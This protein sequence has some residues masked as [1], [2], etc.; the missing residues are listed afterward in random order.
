MVV[1]VAMLG[2]IGVRVT[3]ARPA[4][5]ADWGGIIWNF[6][7]IFQAEAAWDDGQEVFRMN[8]NLPEEK[9]AGWVLAIPSSVADTNVEWRDKMG[10]YRGRTAVSKAREQ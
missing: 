4:E 6:P 2:C 3:M 1:C 8:V 7:G 10:A 5:D 9:G